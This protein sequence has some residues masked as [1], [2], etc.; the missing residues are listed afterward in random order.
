MVLSLQ[1]GHLTCCNAGGAAEPPLLPCSL[2]CTFKE[3]NDTANNYNGLSVAEKMLS[4]WLWWITLLETGQDCL[5]TGKTP[6]SRQ[7]LIKSSLL[8][9]PTCV[10][11]KLTAK[12]GVII[13]CI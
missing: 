3:E 8:P 6:Q 10:C 5:A 11:S 2:V 4:V 9:F 1:R 12:E 7:K 13:D